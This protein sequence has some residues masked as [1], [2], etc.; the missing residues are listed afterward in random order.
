MTNAQ[1]DLKLDDLRQEIREPLRFLWEQL[2][3]SLV[4]NLAGITVVGSALTEDYRPGSSDINTVVVLKRHRMGALAAI[5]AMARPARKK[6]LSPPLL[7]TTSYIEQSRD[8]FGVEF[9]DFQL[10]HQTV[11]GHDPFAALSFAKSDVRLQC[12]R[13]LKAMLIRLRQGYIAAAGNKKLVCD[14]LIAAARGLAP[15]LRAMLWLKD[16]E[17][18]ATIGAALDRASAEFS[19][20]LD[21]VVTA[22]RWRHERPRLSA[23]DL[24]TTFESV[25][26]VVNKLA[27][28][29]DAMEIA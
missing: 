13:E 26:A 20:A 8:V 28:L 27:G 15:F 3:M 2:R 22:V 25:Y 24:E 7:M 21:P 11:L 23:L 16:L 12:E 14:V 9:L 29:V 4:D 18:P 6:H 17:R 1:N 10:T 19:F 5:A